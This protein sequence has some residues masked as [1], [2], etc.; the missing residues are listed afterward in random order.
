MGSIAYAA[1]KRKK[2]R[3]PVYESNEISEEEAMQAELLDA[4]ENREN[5]IY[6]SSKGI[7]SSATSDGAKKQIIINQTK[8]TLPK[9]NRQEKR[10]HRR[11]TFNADALIRQEQTV[12]SGK[13]INISD[14][15]ANLT[16]N[17]Q[18]SIGDLLDLTIYFQHDTKKLSMT[19][20]CKV[21]RI[22]GKGVGITSPHIDAN[23]LQRLELIFDVSKDNTKQ[24][25]ED[26][27]KTI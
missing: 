13:I 22:D 8:K 21:A 11:L 7:F 19:V 1:D 2:A 4:T 5:N 6:G 9:N 23:M 12:Y 15:G 25:I 27:F 17:G 24:L 18:F 3:V 26:F 16:I 14:M 20:P 10:L